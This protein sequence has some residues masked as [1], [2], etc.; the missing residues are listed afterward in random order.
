MRRLLRRPL[1]ARRLRATLA[2]LPVLFLGALVLPA[3]WADPVPDFTLRLLN[4][5][6]ASV[7]AYRGKPVLLSFF[8][9]Q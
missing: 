2:W 1:A 8:H 4:G 3:A 9:S 5:K 6:T 7:R